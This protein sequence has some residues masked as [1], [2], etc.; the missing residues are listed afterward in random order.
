VSNAVRH[1]QAHKIAVA[2]VAAHGT[3]TLRVADDGIGMPSPPPPRSG[4]RNLEQRAQA[5]GG[6]LRLEPNEPHGTILIWSI[7]ATPSG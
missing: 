3:V 7:P 2:L 4:L 6:T 1:G 5:L